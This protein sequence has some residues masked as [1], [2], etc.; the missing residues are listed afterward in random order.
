VQL[1]PSGC[2]RGR[3]AGTPVCRRC[4][5]TGHQPRGAG[6]HQPAGHSRPDVIYCLGGVLQPTRAGKRLLL[7]LRDPVWAQRQVQATA[8]SPFTRGEGIRHPPPREKVAPS[9]PAGPA[10]G[11]CKVVAPVKAFQQ[12]TQE[13]LS[14]SHVYNP[15]PN[16]RFSAPASPP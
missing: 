14:P 13:S 8:P 16:S 6:L 3:S 10:A 4:P 5:A 11:I 7:Q 9:P 12:L 1:H 2:M 15:Q